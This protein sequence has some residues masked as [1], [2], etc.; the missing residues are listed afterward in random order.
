MSNKIIILSSDNVLN[1][2]FSSVLMREETNVI[3]TSNFEELK[4][5][6]SDLDFSVDIILC[7]L[8]F[9]LDSE[10]YNLLN[11]FKKDI[12]NL[13]IVTFTSLTMNMDIVNRIIKIGVYDN[14]IKPI[15]PE[16]LKRS[17]SRAIEKK[18]LLDINTDLEEELK[19]LR[20]TLQALLNADLEQITDSDFKKIKEQMEG[21]VSDIEKR[22]KILSKSLSDQLKTIKE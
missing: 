22:Y 3:S 16:A 4:L 13:Q 21:S 14:L 2:K 7:D 5:A 19:T 17:T 12:K 15:T 10:G 8:E 18:N 6:I 20:K 11:R 1:S 9:V